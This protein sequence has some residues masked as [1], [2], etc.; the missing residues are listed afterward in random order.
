MDGHGPVARHGDPMTLPEMTR[1]QWAAAVAAAAAPNLLR[2]AAAAGPADGF[3]LN[4]SGVVDWSREWA[5]VDVSKASRPWALAGGG[6]GEAADAAGN[7]RPRDGKAVWSLLCRE[8]N[9]HYP[10][11]TY[12]ATWKGAGKLDIKR[13]DV[14]ETLSRSPGRLEFRVEPGHGGIQID[15]SE[16]DPDDPVRDI[17]VWMPGFEGAKSPFHPLFLERIGPAKA[18]RLMDWQRTNGSPLATWAD[19]PTPA[20]ARY[21]TDKGVPVEVMVELANARGVD[22]WFCLPHKADDDFVRQFAKLV[23]A[24]LDPARKVYVEYSNEVWNWQF[25]QTRYAKARGDALKLGDPSHNRYYSQRSVEIFKI[26]E[27]QFGKDRLVRVLASHAVVPWVSEQIV[28]WKD[29]HKHADAL[30]IAPYFGHAFGSPKAVAKTLAMTPDALVAALEKEV[31]GENADHIRKQAA[32]AKKHGLRLL[33]YE[34]GQHMVGTGGAENDEA[35]TAKLI[36]ANRHPR[37][38]DVYR[39]HFA[40]WAAAGG[41]LFAIF[42]NVAAPSK[43]GSWGVLE[44]QDQPTADAPK[45]RAYLDAAK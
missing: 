27:Q 43:W 22:P 20:D 13:W 15:V 31:D 40:H 17:R 37:M 44:Y 19:R 6:K 18:L 11:G 39:K 29:A 4:L 9:G 3:G 41:G 32:V 36:E 16:S 21:S 8:V 2:A 34:G 10:A 23:K 5:F 38:Y 42:S 28:G 33:A 26:W 7:P 14:K 45:Y 1:R 12:V 30:A 25:E 35:L 24:T